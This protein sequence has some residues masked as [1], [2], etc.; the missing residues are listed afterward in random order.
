[1]FA[2]F[3]L[4]IFTLHD[5]TYT[6]AKQPI[7]RLKDDARGYLIAVLRPLVRTD[8]KTGELNFTAA[9]QVQVHVIVLIL[10]EI[11]VLLSTLFAIRIF[12]IVF[13]ITLMICILTALCS[14]EQLVVVG[15]VSTC[16]TCT[17]VTKE[18]KPCSLLVD[19]SFMPTCRY[20]TRNYS[21]IYRPVDHSTINNPLGHANSDVQPLNPRPQLQ[22]RVI[23][24]N[25]IFSGN[26]NRVLASGGEGTRL[27]QSSHLVTGNSDSNINN[28][29]NNS[30]SSTHNLFY[31]V[32]SRIVNP[33]RE[34]RGGLSD[35]Q[36]TGSSASIPSKQTDTDLFDVAL[37]LAAGQKSAVKNMDNSRNSLLSVVPSSGCALLAVEDEIHSDGDG[38]VPYTHNDE[39][40][41]DGDCDF[42][43]HKTHSGSQQISSVD[44]KIIRRDGGVVVPRE[45]SI[46][47]NLTQIRPK[48]VSSSFI[49]RHGNLSTNQRPASAPLSSSSDAT[50]TNSLLSSGDVIVAGQSL[51]IDRDKLKL[52]AALYVDRIKSELPAKKQK[53]AHE[54]IQKQQFLD[55]LLSQKSNHADEEEN[56]WFDAY[57]KRLYKI[58]MRETHLNKEN[59]KKFVTAKA[60]YCQECKTTLEFSNS[61]CRTRGHNV[62]SISTTKRFFECQQ[63]RKRE[64]TLGSA[65][66]PERACTGCNAYD[67][68]STGRNGSGL[69][70][71]RGR[72]GAT[73][74]RCAPIGVMGDK[75]V[76]GANEWAS[77]GDI[78]QLNRATSSL[79]S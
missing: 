65:R 61:V 7:C 18:G 56:E 55:Q 25:S 24:S 8:S 34:N 66:L 37:K 32:D 26:Q 33:H 29:N 51:I 19:H 39:V 5:C 31:K 22:Q 79:D 70:P 13:A 75:L 52:N 35:A 2:Q 72:A 28:R 21:D 10:N 12:F 77:R 36:L 64:F 40:D 62:T 30:G 59:E 20:H 76:T 57:E 53:I 69:P 46:F 4:I 9:T 74:R 14:C 60:F 17:S 43:R 50:N 54:L 23:S 16:S 47:G 67:F 73:G 71:A 27:T 45:A 68:I 41:N 58:Q 1:M 44:S 3:V 49:Q 63:C 15:K 38:H 48:S 6:Q 42:Y 11:S 78:A